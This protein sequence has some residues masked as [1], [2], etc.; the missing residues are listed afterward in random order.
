MGR[1]TRLLIRAA[2]R[3][4]SFMLHSTQQS[5]VTC[6]M[7]ASIEQMLASIGQVG[8]HAD[9]THCLSKDGGKLSSE[10]ELFQVSH[11]R[12]LF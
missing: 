3:L 10:G 12:L 8:E 11:Q 6:S 1:L 4:P 9:H 2:N 5:E 7:A